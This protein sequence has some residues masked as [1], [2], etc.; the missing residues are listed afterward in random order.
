[1][2]V[3]KG[4]EEGTMLACPVGGEGD[5]VV[6]PSD[7]GP[8]PVPPHPAPL[9]WRDIPVPSVVPQVEPRVEYDPWDTWIL[10]LR[11]AAA[12]QFSHLIDALTYDPRV[13][14]HGPEPDIE[15]WLDELPDRIASVPS[16][17]REKY[18]SFLE[19]MYQTRNVALAWVYW[20]PSPEFDS[21]STS[22]KRRIEDA[23]YPQE[24]AMLH[25]RTGARVAADVS[26]YLLS[27]YTVCF[28]VFSTIYRAAWY[29]RQDMRP[30]RLAWATTRTNRRH[31]AGRCATWRGQTLVALTADPACN[32]RFVAIQPLEVDEIFNAIAVFWNMQDLDKVLWS[33][34]CGLKAGQM[35]SQSSLERWRLVLET[36]KVDGQFAD[37]EHVDV[38]RTAA[39]PITQSTLRQY[40]ALR[41]RMERDKLPPWQFLERRRIE[42]RGPIYYTMLSYAELVLSCYKGNGAARHVEGVMVAKFLDIFSGEDVLKA[43]R[44]AAA[45]AAQPDF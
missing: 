37:P 6:R 40:G 34:F 44:L 31:I 42:Q 28:V 13:V 38:M 30:M 9:L 18:T 29:L 16:V 2:G 8:S 33:E 27:W 1:M 14:S 17:V 19:T 7:V 20:R 35:V 25:M 5:C 45:Q 24:G 21:L 43:I 11:S 10:G 36:G 12:M 15:K 41:Q 3:A 26:D 23:Q 32:A 4:E 22:Q 39:L